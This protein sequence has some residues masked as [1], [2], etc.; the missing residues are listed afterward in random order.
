MAGTESPLRGQFP[1]PGMHGEPSRMGFRMNLRLIDWIWRI[2]GS[3][4]LVPDL[5][6]DDAFDR[7]EPLF[8]QPGT[9]HQRTHDTL[10]FTKKDQI[11]QD[12]M[13]VFDRGTLKIEQVAAGPVFRYRLTSRALLFC[14][15]APILFL[16]IGQLTVV[17][18]RF[19]K[20]HHEAAKKH[21]SIVL[22]PLD[23][24]LGAPAPD[25]PN[26]KTSNK[27]DD[28]DDHK[29][30]PVAAYVLAAVFACLYIV[31][32]VLEDRL[33]RLLLKRS[34]LAK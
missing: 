33:L 13:S 10:T 16:C 30:K 25:D 18:A 3:F 19:E 31:G 1:P 20:P 17:I 6:N 23:R 21:E 14:F 24:A 7:L 32:R 26:K 11:A 9:C 29:L 15:L 2:R 34:L 12:K 5:S 28:E 22:N 27:S 8:R 4:V